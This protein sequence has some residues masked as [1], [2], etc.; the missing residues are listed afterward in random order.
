MDWAASCNRDIAIMPESGWSEIRP[1]LITPYCVM[2]VNAR[3]KIV[4]LLSLALL[5]RPVQ[6]RISAKKLT[7]RLV[8]SLRVALRSLWCD[9]YC[10]H[11]L[12]QQ[13]AAHS[14]CW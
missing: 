5:P 12:L 4:T 11:E 6:N 3:A 13:S 7:V 9:M 10:P 8:A 14:I 2:C 1:P